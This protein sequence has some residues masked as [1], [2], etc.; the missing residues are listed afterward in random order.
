VDAART[1]GGRQHER[2]K[3]FRRDGVQNEPGDR[4]SPS[5]GLGDATKEIV[6]DRAGDFV[7]RSLLEPSSDSDTECLTGTAVI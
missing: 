7:A 5:M 3:A 6:R 2:A 4:T 1:G